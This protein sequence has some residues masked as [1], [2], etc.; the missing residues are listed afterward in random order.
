MR[1][2]LIAEVSTNHGGDMAIAKDFIWRFAEAGADWIK[3]QHTRVKHLRPDD[4]QYAW[5]QQAE[6]S[7][8][9][10]A[11]LKAECERA[12]VKFLTTVFNHQD[13]PAVRAL[14]DTVK[15]GSGE[16]KEVDLAFAIVKHGFTRAIVGCGLTE[17]DRTAIYGH[18]LRLDFL[19]CVTRYPCPVVACLLD[20]RYGHR[21]HGWSDH[22]VGLDACRMAIMQGARIIEKHVKLHNQA[23]PGRPFEA[24]AH[25]FKQLRAFAD[26]DPQRFLG[27]WQCA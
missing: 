10:F 14:T 11:E 23:R 27:R 6:L 17:A 18:A 4:Q 16:A 7:D 21:Y 5:F 9:Q 1:I 13:V 24:T 2:E 20:G 22:C 25:A 19:A 3:F 12:G 15:I 8:E 26:E